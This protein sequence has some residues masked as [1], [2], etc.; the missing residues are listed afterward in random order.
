MATILKFR[1]CR[2]EGGR[3][4]AT[5]RE[6]RKQGSPAEVI[7]FPRLTLKNLCHIAQAMTAGRDAT[8]APLSTAS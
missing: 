1:S 4:P 5:K 2:D 7:M 8:G 3:T 6:A